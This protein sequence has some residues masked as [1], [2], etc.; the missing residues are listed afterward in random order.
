[1]LWPILFTLTIFVSLYDL[2]TQRIPNWVTLP[3][4]IAGLI[5]HFPGVNETMLASAI[6]VIAFSSGWMGFLDSGRLLTRWL[7]RGGDGMGTPWIMVG[8]GMEREKPG[9]RWASNGVESEL[10]NKI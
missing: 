7:R 3:L 5:V 4:L 2:R 9:L 8:L 1:M 6:L 10:L